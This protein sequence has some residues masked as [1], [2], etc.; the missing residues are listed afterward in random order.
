MAP[1][2]ATEGIRVTLRDHG[3]VFTLDAGG[4]TVS[5]GDRIGLTGAS[6]TG[7]T[8]LLELL[9]LLRR[10]DPGGRYLVADGGEVRDVAALWPHGA[11]T[12]ATLR[13]RLFGFVPQSGGLL[14][15]LDVRQNVALSQRIAGK[16]D[17]AFVTTLIDRLGLGAVAAM[18]PAGL[19]IGQRQ[20]VAI[21]RALAH[22]PGFVIA[23]EPTAALDPDAAAE[24]IA[25]LFEAARDGGAAV[26]VSSHDI[27]LLDRFPLRRYALTA[28]AG[29]EGAVTSR[30]VA[31]E[32]VPCA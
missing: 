15:F 3:R 13:G 14:P 4:L 26:I 30:L 28:S 6:G 22:R 9:G 24:A 12:I 19:S 23:D 27:A 21:A 25:L 1:A 7:K 11:G 8:L 10:P 29:G 18:R 5:P 32:P 17:P 20:R 31:P 2:L 16:V